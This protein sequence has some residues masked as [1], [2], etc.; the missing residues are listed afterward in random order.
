MGRLERGF[1]DNKDQLIRK[2]GLSEPTNEKEYYRQEA[3]LKRLYQNK[4]PHESAEDYVRNLFGLRDSRINGHGSDTIDNSFS[5]PI[6]YEIK[7]S[8]ENV[9]IPNTQF[10]HEDKSRHYVI[11]V[12]R[13]DKLSTFEF[14]RKK[15]KRALKTFQ[16]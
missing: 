8:I 9:L 15:G 10:Y 16:E 13:E 12:K 1:W 4:R 3:F 14:I 5:P 7:S 6:H 11:A 2:L